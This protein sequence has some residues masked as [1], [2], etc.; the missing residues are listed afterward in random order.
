[1][2]QH[3]STPLTDYIEYPADEMLARSEQ[4]QY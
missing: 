1:M 4:T 3:D 2:K